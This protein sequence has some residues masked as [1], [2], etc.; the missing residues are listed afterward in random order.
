[1]S[2]YLLLPHPMFSILT[3]SSLFFSLALSASV[4]TTSNVGSILANPAECSSFYTCTHEGKGILQSCPAGLV[5]NPVTKVCDWPAN[6]DCD[7]GNGNNEPKKR[8]KPE[9]TPAFVDLTNEDSDTE[10]E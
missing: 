3:S 8:K 1:M 6:V 5:F 7:A 9:P 2:N 4:C 10:N